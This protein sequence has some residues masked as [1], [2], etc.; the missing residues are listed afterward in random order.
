M[1][2]H[3]AM[4]AKVFGRNNVRA[5]IINI[6]VLQ[7]VGGEILQATEFRDFRQMYILKLN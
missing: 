6:T 7:L 5:V 2:E 4:Y 3:G 1:N